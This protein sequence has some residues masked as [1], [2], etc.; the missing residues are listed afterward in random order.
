MGQETRLLTELERRQALKIMNHALN[1]RRINV[2][3]RLVGTEDGRQVSRVVL[4]KFAV[5]LELAPQAP[6]LRRLQ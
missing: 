1:H 3:A 4:D 6:D 2:L 5:T